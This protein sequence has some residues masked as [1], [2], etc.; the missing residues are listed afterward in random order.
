MMQLSGEVIWR[1]TSRF[2]SRKK[3]LK[4]IYLYPLYGSCQ[5]VN[6]Q[7]SQH[8][9]NLRVKLQLRANNVRRGSIL[10]LTKIRSTKAFLGMKRHTGASLAWSRNREQE[11]DVKEQIHIFVS[12]SYKTWMIAHSTE[13]LLY[14]NAKSWLARALLICQHFRNVISGVTK[15]PSRLRHWNALTR[16]IT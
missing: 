10:Q 9:L 3:Y 16:I 5:H 4:S 11:S 1:A 8:F 7:Q 12:L 6:L 13:R 14:V 15:W 2:E